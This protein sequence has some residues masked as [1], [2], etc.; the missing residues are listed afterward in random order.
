MDL[1][2]EQA[3]DEPGQL[4]L[5][6]FVL[7][8]LW[9]HRRGGELHHEAYKAIGQLEGAIA[10]KA[11][12]LC[13]KLSEA[14]QR[15]VQQ[16]FLRLVRP[17]EGEADTRRR[18]TVEEIGEGLQG[19]VKMLA[20][21]RLL[22]T[23]HAGDGAEE[24]IE[25]SHEALIRNWGQ[26]KKWVDDDRQFLLWQQ[27]LGVSIKGWERSKRSSDLLLRGLPLA[28]S[29][30]WLKNKPEYFSP[31]ERKFV[32]ASKNRKIRDRIAAASFAGLVLLL[33]GGPLGWLWMG[34]MTVQY[35]GSIVLARLHLVSVPE[36]EMVEIPKGNYR[37][38]DLRNSGDSREQPVREVTI[39]PFAM[40]RYE[41]TF[42]EYDRY[43]EL[44]TGVVPAQCVKPQPDAR[45]SKVPNDE[46][47]GREKRPVINVSW[48]EAVVYSKWLSKATGKQYRL[49]MEFEWQYA[50][51]SG[52][53][54]DIWAGTSD[55]RDLENYGVYSADRTEPVGK[56]KPNYL[57]L[58]DM[59]GNVWEWVQDCG[60]QELREY[61][62]NTR[63][64]K[65]GSWRNPPEDLRFG[66]QHTT[67]AS[68]RRDIIGFRLAQDIP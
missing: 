17:G 19:L 37:Q 30:D 7:R 42:E 16:I 67:L 54:N 35:A 58:Y 6:E 1:I 10:K 21:E 46:G 41:V 31:E 60:K 32:T 62:C 49:P 34:E 29:L 50:E 18:A 45:C 40:G 3:G 44:T 8:Q 2:L 15:K 23:S 36:P 66:S 24:T 11:E 27:R 51:R 14:D 13:L 26:L 48:D 68:V 57:G 63:V 5:L 9:A 28:E 38:G 43:L 12:S 61:K 4:P 22:V 20:D 65:G 59:N 33:I 47:W 25:V 52:E 56:K 64:I 55:E 39:K 53:R